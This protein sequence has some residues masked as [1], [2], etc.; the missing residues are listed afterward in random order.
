[1]LLVGEGRDEITQFI[2]QFSHASMK[3][4]LNTT[5]SLWFMLSEKR[6]VRRK[7]IGVFRV[8]LTLYTS[9]NIITAFIL[10]AVCVV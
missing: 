8:S 1:V 4:Y 2:L 10:E 3:C 6:A 9:T 5:G 7:R